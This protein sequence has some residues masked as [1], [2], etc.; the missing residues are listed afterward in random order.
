MMR[1]MRFLGA[2]RNWT[3]GHWLRSVIV[4]VTIL[5]LIGITIGGWA[6][7][8]SVAIHTGEL[9]SEAAMKAY[10]E[11]RYEEARASV[12][13]MLTSGR[14]PREEFGGPL[15]VLGAI[16]TKDADAQGTAERRRVDYLIASRY[17]TEARAYGIPENRA[18][19][20]NT[21]WAKA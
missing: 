16:K 15:L 21:C 4:G 19:L 13:H 6:Y 7:L 14:L 2:L 8:A 9:S 5:S 12:G 10:D 18:P 11:G 3:T 17:L 20:A 1:F